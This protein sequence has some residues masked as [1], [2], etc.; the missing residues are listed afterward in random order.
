[1]VKQFMH[2]NKHLNNDACRSQKLFCDN[3]KTKFGVIKRT[4]LCIAKF[5]LVLEGMRVV[6]VAEDLVTQPV[7][8]QP[9]IMYGFVNKQRHRKM[10]TSQ[11]LSQC[12]QKVHQY[13]GNS[14]TRHS[15]AGLK[16]QPEAFQAG[17]EM[18]GEFTTGAVDSQYTKH[19]SLYATDFQCVWAVVMRK[20]IDSYAK[21]KRDSCRERENG[22]G[23]RAVI[24]STQWGV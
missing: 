12:M 23:C 11:S 7:I 17:L 4:Q 14:K 16:S 13:G 6:R 1:M 21:T 19:L 8:L 18:L 5:G 24:E 3:L 20:D 22:R 10:L 2:I 9:T 15:F